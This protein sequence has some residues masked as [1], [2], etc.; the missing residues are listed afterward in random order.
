M[1]F[2]SRRRRA[3]LTAVI[4]SFGCSSQGS[5]SGV[6]ELTGAST[7]SSSARIQTES[8]FPTPVSACP[9]GKGTLDSSCARNSAVFMKDVEAAIDLLAAQKPE[10]FDLK[11]Q[12]SAGSYRVLDVD[13]YYEGVVRNLQAAGFCA[14]YDLSEIQVKNSN[15]FSEQYDVL[16]STLHARRGAGSYRSTCAP[17]IFPLEASDYIHSV[18]VAFFG[19]SCKNGKDAPPNGVGSLPV[20]CEGSVTATPKTKD[21]V[22]V[23][24]RIHGPEIAWRIRDGA[25]RIHVDDFPGVAF[26]K[27]VT[28]LEEG[29]FSVCATVKGVEGCLNGRVIP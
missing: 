9:I 12:I 8:P 26:N 19:I 25:E 16:L 29:E 24:P 10:I 14:N 22:D 27:S 23:D 21:N 13:A 3:I 1:T 5:R 28:G 4:V 17:A 18:R 20:G 7:A 11:D 15:E 6:R 2:P